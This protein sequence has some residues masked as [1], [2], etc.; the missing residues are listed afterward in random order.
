MGE[1]ILM[2]AQ[3]VGMELT[4]V[5][6][7]YNQGNFNELE[8]AQLLNL[9]SAYMNGLQAHSG[10]NVNLFT[11][12]LKPKT[13]AILKIASTLSISEGSN[14]S[15]EF[16]ARAIE[17]NSGEFNDWGLE[18]TFLSGAPKTYISST[19]NSPTNKSPII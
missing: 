5:P 7:Y 4:L 1:R 10:E 14:K 15:L 8:A 2:A 17:I 11:N 16:I 19:E 6:I 3:E 12:K 9:S 18:I 13:Q